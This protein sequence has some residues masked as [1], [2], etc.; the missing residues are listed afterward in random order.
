MSVTIATVVRAKA[1]RPDGSRDDIVG[2]PIY[3]RDRQYVRL[4][5]LRPPDGRR[6]RSEMQR[7]CGRDHPALVICS[8][9]GNGMPGTSPGVFYG[10]VGTLR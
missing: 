4:L 6:H 1:N 8:A 2:V 3:L 5:R 9:M 7:V 10:A